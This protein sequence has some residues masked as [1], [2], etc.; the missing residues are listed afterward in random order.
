MRYAGPRMLLRHPVLALA[1]LLVDGRR[2]APPKLR[3][4]AAARPAITD[5]SRPRRGT[6]GD[7]SPPRSLPLPPG[8]GEIL[9]PGHSPAC[10]SAAGERFLI[11]FK[12]A[13][14]RSCTLY[15]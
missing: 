2:P 9:P 12:A 7:G 14:I 13:A 15:R 8:E 3:G 5:D 6:E 1:H 11:W 10:A 4:A